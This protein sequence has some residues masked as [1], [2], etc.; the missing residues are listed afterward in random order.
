MLQSVNWKGTEKVDGTNIRVMWDGI[1]VTFGGKTERAQ[2]PADL[3]NYLKAT[4]RQ[5]DL[6][7]AF[8]SVAD[9]PGFKLCLYGEGYG[10]KIQKGGGNY[11]SDGVGF[12][13]FDVWIDGWW[14]QRDDI[15]DVAHKLNIPYVPV[16]FEGTLMQAVEFIKEAHKSSVAENRDHIIEGLVLKPEVELFNRKGERIVTKI[17]VAD[18]APV[19]V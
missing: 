12:I 5:E 16:I 14:L 13:L 7:D 11:I 6:F 8:G 2:I 9:E 19:K 1:N 3:V 17:K 4:F 10:A 15:V 18:F